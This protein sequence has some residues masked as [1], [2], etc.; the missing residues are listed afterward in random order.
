[1]IISVNG[2]FAGLRGLVV[3][4]VRLL[5]EGPQVHVQGKIILSGGEATFS[6]YFHYHIIVSYNLYCSVLM[7]VRKYV[8]KEGNK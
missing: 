5:N 3:C 7:K 2:E 6:H 8:N 1:M 4:S